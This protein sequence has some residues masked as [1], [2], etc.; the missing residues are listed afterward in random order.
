VASKCLVSF[1]NNIIRVAKLYA[2]NWKIFFQHPQ[3]KENTKSN[4]SER[5]V[6]DILLLKGKQVTYLKVNEFYL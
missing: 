4:K 6:L 5:I 3:T 2:F 1:S